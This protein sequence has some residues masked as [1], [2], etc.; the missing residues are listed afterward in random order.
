MP[1]PKYLLVTGTS[2]VELRRLTGLDGRDTPHGVLAPR[3]VP[4]SEI[5]NALA[6]VRR[7]IGEAPRCGCQGPLHRPSCTAWL[8]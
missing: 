1:R 3:P 2:A 5:E 8:T 7:A 4:M 6:E